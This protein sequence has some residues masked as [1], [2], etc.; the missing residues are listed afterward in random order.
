MQLPVSRY[1]RLMSPH[2]IVYVLLLLQHTICRS[3]WRD[4]LNTLSI[5]GEGCGFD[6]LYN[7]LE[8]ADGCMD[9][10]FVVW[11]N[12]A[13]GVGIE[14]MGDCLGRVYQ[15]HILQPLPA[16]IQL[17]R[18]TPDVLL[19]GLLRAGGNPPII[20]SDPLTVRLM[21]GLTVIKQLFLQS[22]SNFSENFLT[23]WTEV[24]AKCKA[25]LQE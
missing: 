2:G 15:L 21:E 19:L 11:S 4:N 5:D 14:D 20:D 25:T 9:A 16:P 24:R 23:C 7:Q 12:V 8:L 22:F 3:C 17:M 6:Q 13:Y 1:L 10:W 18:P